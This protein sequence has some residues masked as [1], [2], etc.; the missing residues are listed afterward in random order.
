MSETTPHVTGIYTY[1][2][3]SFDSRSVDR[4]PIVGSGGL[5]GDRAYAVV[6]LDD[7]Y[8]NG[9]REKQTHRVRTTYTGPQERIE[10]VTIETPTQPEQTVSVTTAEGRQSLCR[11]LE[12]YLGY[13]V[14]LE[15]NDS[16]GFPDD[17]VASGP[18]IISTATIE[19]VAGWFDGISADSMRR[20]L[21]A[22]IEIGG[23]EPFWE[24]R[25]FTDRDHYVSFTI[26]DTTLYGRNPC[27][28]CVV[29]SRDPDTGA[30]YPNFN[31]QFATKRRETMPP[32]SG[33]DWFDHDFRLMVNTA[34]TDEAIGSQLS[35][36][37]HVVIG[38][39]VPT[40]DLKTR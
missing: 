35:V 33:G 12:S 1:P 8:V 18:T 6:D 31:T 3:K 10:S 14:T 30:E 7:N 26:G 21:R 19:T 23:V 24:D 34:V 37:D 20:R 39:S 25:L 27:Q 29:P 36:G 11:F 15:H 17:T 9:K 40:D 38:D 28:R 5:A 22:N 32:W 13:P 16:G 4:V 2:I